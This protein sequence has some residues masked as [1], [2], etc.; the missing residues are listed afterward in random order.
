MLLISF[1]LM[2]AINPIVRRTRRLRIPTALTVIFFYAI[3]IAIMSGS[4]ASLIPAVTSQTK[5]L[6]TQIPKIL[7]EIESLFNLRIDPASL[8]PQFSSVPSN[9]LKIAVGTFS[10]LLNI[11]AIF[12][13]TYYMIQERDNLHRYLVRFF[14][15]SSAERKAEKLVNDLELRIGG[16]IRGEIALMLVI[17][18]LTY[19]GLLLLNIPYALPLA[20]LAGILEL[21]PNIGPTL[22]AIPAILM[23]LTVSPVTALGALALSILVQQLENNIIVPQVMKKAVGTKPLTTI[24]VLFTGLTLGGV[25]GAILAMPIY[26]MLETVFTHLE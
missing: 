9:I 7:G 2:T 5:G 13:M 1:I 22:A 26:L 18:T 6:T 12:F 19:I 8:T 10:N 21:V 16:W 17:G 15:N 4:V 11:M 25:M 20:V 3:L 23:G 14:G 24:I